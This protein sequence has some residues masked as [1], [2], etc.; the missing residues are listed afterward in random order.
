MRSGRSIP[1]TVISGLPW[2]HLFPHQGRIEMRKVWAAAI[3]A[4]AVLV[5]ISNTP[6]VGT[7]AAGNPWNVTVLRFAPGTSPAEMAAVVKDLGAVVTTDLS[8]IGMMAVVS[9]D[10]SLVT[11]AKGNS[12]VKSAWLDKVVPFTL[13]D[14]VAPGGQTGNNE[15]PLGNPGATTPPDPWHNATSFLGETNPEGILQWDDNRMR[16]PGAWPTTVGD[17]TVRVAVVDTGVEGSHKELLPNYDNQ[18]SANT[19]PCNTLTREF[20][21]GLG[22]K[23][24][25]AADTEGHGT[26]VASRI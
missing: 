7:P 12:K 5:G 23:D 18:S 9:K 15:P 1:L 3:V 8:K 6:A 25:S 22:E 4:A 16:V 10:Q 11:K 26:W 2:R 24:C 13:P 21:P 17:N 20:G 14:A 19:I